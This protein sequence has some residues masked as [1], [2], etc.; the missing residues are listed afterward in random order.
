LITISPTILIFGGSTTIL[1]ALMSRK[2]GY[3][4]NGYIQGREDVFVYAMEYVY[5]IA[6]GICLFGA[7]LTAIRLS[8][9]KRNIKSVSRE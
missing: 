5:I 4:V 1:Y 8:R 6:A 2:V 3:Q 7:L 9:S